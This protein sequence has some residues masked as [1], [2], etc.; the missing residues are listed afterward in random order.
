MLIQEENLYINLTPIHREVF[1]VLKLLE[2]QCIGIKIQVFNSQLTNQEHTH[3]N[4]QNPLSETHLNTH[5][6]LC[7]TEVSSH[8]CKTH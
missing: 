1:S 5:N 2:N 4:L 6:C 8:N 7:E 3:L